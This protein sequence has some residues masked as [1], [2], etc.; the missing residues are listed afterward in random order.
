MCINTPTAHKH[1]QTADNYM[2]KGKS[3]IKT[4]G[5]KHAFV[6]NSRVKLWNAG[7]HFGRL[8]YCDISFNPLLSVFIKTIGTSVSVL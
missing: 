6:C 1:P 5:P 3:D 7:L 4:S 8:F 2:L